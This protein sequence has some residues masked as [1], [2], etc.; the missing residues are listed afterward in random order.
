MLS[1][2]VQT[3]KYGT[4]AKESAMQMLLHIQILLYM[5]NA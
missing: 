2:V 1:D 5:S 3:A 4:A